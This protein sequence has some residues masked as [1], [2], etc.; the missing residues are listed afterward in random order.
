MKI[1]KSANVI[2]VIRAIKVNVVIRLVIIGPVG[3]V[4]RKKEKWIKIVQCTTLSSLVGIVKR[5]W[6]IYGSVFIFNQ[7]LCPQCFL[8]CSKNDLLSCSLQESE[9][10]TNG[11]LLTYLC[12]NCLMHLRSLVG[13]E[14]FP[15]LLPPKET[16][17]TSRYSIVLGFF[18]MAVVQT[19]YIL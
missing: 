13:D 3:K 1:R 10:T 15:A 11:L 18:F 17:L 19:S 12:C 8:Q 6:K 4:P 5:T 7:R 14:L 9:P 16:L 2:I